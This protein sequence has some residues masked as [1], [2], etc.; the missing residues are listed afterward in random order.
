MKLNLI[1]IL[2]GNV[3]FCQHVLEVATG[4]QQQMKIQAFATTHSPLVLASL[5]P[6]FDEEIDR[7]FLFELQ[8]E[9]VTLNEFP[10][11]NKEIQSIG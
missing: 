5:E 8:E 2:S 9:E 11:Q 4:L 10:G 3:Q 1:S 6:I 7:L